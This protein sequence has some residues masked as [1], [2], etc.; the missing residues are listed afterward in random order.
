MAGAVAAAVVSVSVPN[1]FAPS[2]TKTAFEF[3]G[4]TFPLALH[5]HQP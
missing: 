1:N 3:T 4:S 2:K 5:I